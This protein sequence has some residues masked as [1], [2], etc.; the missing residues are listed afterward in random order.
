MAT[1]SYNFSVT[2]FGQ[3]VSAIVG[4]AIASMTARYL[5]AEAR[6][7]YYLMLA[8]PMTIC[9]MI[10]FGMP[11]SIVYH[12]GKLHGNVTYFHLQ[13]VR[14][15]ALITLAGTTIALLIVYE[16]GPRLFPG[17]ELK[18]LY[19]SIT[20]IPIATSQGMLS[21]LLSGLEKFTV[22]A[23]ADVSRQITFLIFL[24]AVVFAFD[25]G[26]IGVY[27][28][29]M[30][31]M[32]IVAATLLRNVS[33]LRQEGSPRRTVTAVSGV[34]LL[35][36]G[37]KNHV[38]NI[39]TYLEYRIDIFLVALYLG[40]EPV[41]VYSVSVAVAEKIWLIANSL[42]NVIFSRLANEEQREE[43]VT[44]MVFSAKSVLSLSFIASIIVG[45]TA[46]ILVPAVFGNDFSNSVGPLIILLPGVAL[47][48]AVKVY[49]AYIAAEG[50][51]Q[52]NI[53]AS[54]VSL[55]IN[56]ATNILLIPSFGVSG[57]ATATLL[58][59]AANYL[60]RIVIVSRISGHGLA[61]LFVVTQSDAR[62]MAAHL[63]PSR[64]KT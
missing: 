4:I 55:A 60:I 51:P 13:L 35:S 45:I 48:S 30:T 63:I 40:P 9:T 62:R 26:I 11:A 53:V 52:W 57:A 10:D 47:W 39:I 5:G 3:T 15:W 21:A 12:V 6:G 27:F 24:T 59:Y 29:E 31:A 37:L 18:Y 16:F 50:V 64:A 20:L 54:I 43:R 49:G 19:L 56:I 32:A 23:K 44:L 8:Y 41:G 61:N 25:L 28:A 58:S 2:V 33:L 42:S 38:A 7:I 36:Y 22:I 14:I 17:V 34:S 1:V 46:P